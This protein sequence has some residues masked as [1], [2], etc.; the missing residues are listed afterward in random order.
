[1]EA[2]DMPDLEDASRAP[3][4]L[5]QGSPLGHRE[6][7]R[8]LD[9]AVL[10]GAQALGGERTMTVGRGHQIHRVDLG[11]AGA[12]IRHDARGRDPRPDGEGAALLGRVGNPEVDAEL[13]EHAEVL[14]P[15]APQADQEDLHRGA[16]PSPPR[17]S[18]TS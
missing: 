8:F 10:A 7:E 2:E 17:S 15:P 4:R 6:G 18:A 13:G 11:Q 3:L 14:L 5:R 16:G 12:E 9:E 1:M